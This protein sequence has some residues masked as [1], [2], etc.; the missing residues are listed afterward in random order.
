M[1]RFVD[2]YF[3]ATNKID[4]FLF[5]QAGSNQQL[6]RLEELLVYVPDAGGGPAELAGRDRGNGRY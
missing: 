5:S 3:A 2:E 1:A 4:I 6:S